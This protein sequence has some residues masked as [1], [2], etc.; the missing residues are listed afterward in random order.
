MLDAKTWLDFQIVGG[1]VYFNNNFV[2][3][4]N[5]SVRHAIQDRDNLSEDD[6]GYAVNRAPY[7]VYN[8]NFVQSLIGVWSQG[9]HAVGISFG[10]YSYIDARKID[11]TIGRF[12]ENGVANYTAQHLI[13]YQ[14]NKFR[15][16][17]LAYGEAKISYAYTFKKERQ[18]M[19]MAGFSFKKIFP[20]VGSGI[21][22]RNLDYN[23]NND[24]VLHV[25]RLVADFMVQPN[26][27][28]NMRGGWGLDLGF[29]YQKMKGVARNYYPNSKK[30]SCKR[31]FYKYKVGV[32]ILDLGYAKFPENSITYVGYELNPFDILNYADIQADIETFPEQ[33]I[34]NES[35]PDQGFINKPHKMSLPTSLSVQFDYNLWKNLVY[36]NAT[37]V[38]GIPP[39]RWAFG[40]RRAHSLSVTPRFESK[41]FDLALPLSLYEYRYPQLG[42]SL[43]LWFLT[44]GTD[45]L[46]NMVSRTDVY[47]AD[48]YF[49][50]KWPITR[51]PKCKFKGKNKNGGFRKKIGGKWVKI[52][53]C[54][55][56]H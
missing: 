45:K 38:H 6:L 11:E 23:V 3:G 51:N 19:L 9:D 10:G 42:A 21:S 2:Y 37:W 41:W 52:P 56:Y 53:Y 46:I 50:L 12:I 40:P 35:S 29:T 54:D 17:A 36:V 13:D 5:T 22:I 16:N 31:L 43:R 39:F 44:I 14:F 49:H 8:R 25:D 33:F 26:P 15:A 18:D 30:G 55:A 32:S 1:G 20:V 4:R 7:H 27:G 47:G 28:F 24:T 48:I 34:E